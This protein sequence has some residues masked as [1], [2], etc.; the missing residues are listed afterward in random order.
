VITAKQILA[1]Q[2]SALP[3]ESG[4]Q[5]AQFECP[6]RADSGHSTSLLHC[7]MSFNATTYRN[8]PASALEAEVRKPTLVR[9]GLNP[10][11]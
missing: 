6:L 5:N 7:S 8:K 1:G 2:M 4:H 11:C 9:D 10:V 3:P